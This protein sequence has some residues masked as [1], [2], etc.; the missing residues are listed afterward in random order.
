M[1][2]EHHLVTQTI[3]KCIWWTNEWNKVLWNFDIWLHKDTK[4]C[5]G[6]TN[7]DWNIHFGW[8]SLYKHHNSVEL[9]CCIL[10]NTWNCHIFC[11]RTEENI[12]LYGVFDGHDGSHVAHFAAQR[13]PAELLLGQFR[14]KEDSEEIKKILH[15]VSPFDNVTTTFLLNH[16]WLLY[17]QS[18]EVF[19]CNNK[20]I[21]ASQKIVICNIKIIHI[22]KN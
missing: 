20:T 1:S 18:P 14:D 10:W 6:I 5:Y 13:M 22:S 7:F 9:W 16:D 8:L 21:S 11:C 15:D 12:C 19:F 17:P 2:S 4:H 3:L